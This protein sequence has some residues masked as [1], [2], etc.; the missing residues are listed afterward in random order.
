MIYVFFIAAATTYV[1]FSLGAY[2]QNKTCQKEITKLKECYNNKCRQYTAQMVAYAKLQAYI[3]Y[4]CHKCGKLIAKDNLHWDN[5]KP[6]CQ[7]CK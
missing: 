3:Q 5:D 2:I 7:R 4:R 6:I 1:I